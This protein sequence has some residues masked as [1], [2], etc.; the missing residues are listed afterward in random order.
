MRLK[1]TIALTALL[2]A[3]VATQALAHHGWRWATNE[4]FELSGTIVG[5]QLGN[6][7]GEVTL[8]SAGETWTVEVGQPWRNARAGLEDSLL[9]EGTEIIV[10][11]HRSANP[12]QLVVK[13][14][15][16]VID[17]TSY[18]LYPDRAS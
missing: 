1:S 11:G 16:I 7:H 12:E 4:Q 6:P 13:A 18:D 15:R 14:E 9:R 8:S 2:W 10:H 3:L 17:G 5:V